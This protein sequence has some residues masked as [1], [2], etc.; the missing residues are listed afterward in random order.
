MSGSVTVQPLDNAKENLNFAVDNKP[1]VPFP[2]KKNK[3]GHFFLVVLI[4]RFYFRNRRVGRS[5]D[6]CKCQTHI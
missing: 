3:T 4:V 5:R 1:Y 6:L 2:L